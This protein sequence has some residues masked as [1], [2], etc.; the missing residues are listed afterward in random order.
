MLAFAEAIIPGSAATRGADELTVS[1][2]TDLL[3]ALS[4]HAQGP[5]LAAV[6]LLDQV[7][8]LQAGKPFHGLDVARQEGLLAAWEKSPVLRAPLYALSLLL[9]SA[10]FDLS[11]AA[12][13]PRSE[14]RVVT[15]DEARLESRITPADDWKESSDIECDV[16][17]IGTGAGGAVVGRE[18]ADRGFAVV[19][20][21]EGR[22]QRKE[23]Y[24]G[25]LINAQTQ[26]NRTA[27]ALGASPFPLMMG[28]LVGGSTAINGG[29]CFRT[30]ASTLDE[31]CELLDTDDLS[32][33]NMAPRFRHVEER[34]MVSEPERRF[35]GPIADM[36]D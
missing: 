13:N 36:M 17:V 6:A 34:L 3:S 9:K 26:Y 16:V 30:P 14:L 21:E 27:V 29:T 12:P 18:L 1:K 33:S 15:R 19:F 23:N 25:G 10:H 22:W 24:L 11:F 8:R 2:A 28:K 7:A 5:F 4:P 31:W 20:V 35:I 32:P